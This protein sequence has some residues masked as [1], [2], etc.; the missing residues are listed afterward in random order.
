MKFQ[1]VIRVT[2]STSFQKYQRCNEEL[3]KKPT[4]LH[5]TC[6]YKPFS[7]SEK[8]DRDSLDMGVE[9]CLEL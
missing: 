5:I 6:N 9:F 7:W 3:Q 8:A 1:R 2:N 4:K